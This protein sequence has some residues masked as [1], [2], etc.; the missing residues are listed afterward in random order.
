[1]EVEVLEQAIDEDMGLGFAA[2]T[3]NTEVVKTLW[4]DGYQ[5]P[6]VKVVEFDYDDET[7][8]IV[9]DNRLAYDVPRE[10]LPT[11]GRL[12]ANA[13]AVAAGR[14]SFGENS[15][16]KNPYG[17]ALAG[18]VTKEILGNPVLDEGFEE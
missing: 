6:N 11:V 7:V 3:L 16:I 18:Y 4:V 15:N 1:M 12:V 14:T 13:M 17:K 9:L 8:S 2:V 10:L 5:V